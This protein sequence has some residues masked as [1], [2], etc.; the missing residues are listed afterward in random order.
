MLCALFRHHRLIL[1]SNEL[2]LRQSSAGLMVGFELWMII[3]N[4][5]A[6]TAQN[7]GLE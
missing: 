3:A 6:L 4:T 2:R 5:Q 1:F 7:K